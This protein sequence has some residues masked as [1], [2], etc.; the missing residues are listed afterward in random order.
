MRLD[1]DPDSRR[2]PSKYDDDIGDTVPKQGMAIVWV[3]PE[4]EAIIADRGAK[5]F[6]SVNNEAGNIV[7]LRDS[8][9]LED[10]R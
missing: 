3:S 6:K 8:E 2:G 4:V 1:T 7:I 10:P 5:G 9:T